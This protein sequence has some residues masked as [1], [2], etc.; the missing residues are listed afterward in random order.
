MKT[1]IFETFKIEVPKSALKKA[2]QSHKKFALQGK[3]T[4]SSPLSAI[5][6]VIETNKLNLLT[7]DGNKALV[8]YIEILASEGEINKQSFLLSMEQTSKV[9]LK[10]DKL[11]NSIAIIK[12][13]DYIEF[14]D[15]TYETTQKLKTRK[16]DNFPNIITTIPTDN[17]F[18]I[19]VMPYQIKALASIKTDD[20]INIFFNTKPDTKKVLLVEAKTVN[21]EQQAVICCTT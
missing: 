4:E 16:K 9:V 13:G 1:P 21:L 12:K 10:K 8:S 3:N 2:I 18:H 11:L 17:S 6:F 15:T 7:T 19:S 20:V 14:Q 5:Q